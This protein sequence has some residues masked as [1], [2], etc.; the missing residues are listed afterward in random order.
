MFVR[1]VGVWSRISHPFVLGFLGF[2]LEMEKSSP[3]AWLISPWEPLGNVAQYL[4]GRE[5]SWLNLLG[6]VSP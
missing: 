6:L 1:E 2:H 5:V 3:E 4:A